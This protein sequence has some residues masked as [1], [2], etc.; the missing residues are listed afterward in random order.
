MFFL[1]LTVFVVIAIWYFFIKPLSYWKLR[2]VHHSKTPWYIFGDSWRTFQLLNGKSAYLGIYDFSVPTLCITDPEII[3]KI[4][5]KDFDSFVDHSI[6][7]IDPEI[8]P[9]WGSTL[10]TSTG[11]HWKTLRTVL[12]P[13]FTSSKLKEMFNLVLEQSQN[14]VKVISEREGE[15][16]IR[17]IISRFTNDVIASTAFGANVNSLKEPNNEFY[18]K[19]LHFTNFQTM[20]ILVRLLLLRFFPALSKKMGL[21]VIDNETS[22]FFDTVIKDTIKER[23]E[24][25]FKRLDMINTFLEVLQEQQNNPE[26]F[27]KP[28]TELDLL[29]NALIFYF[30]GFESVASTLS[31]GMYEL[32]LN[33]DIQE[34]LR[35]EIQEVTAKHST[36]TLDVVQSMTY[37]DMVV[38]EILRKWPPFLSTDR[39]LTKPYTLETND[40]SNPLIHL[41]YE[42]RIFVPIYGLHHDP[43]YFP[44]P[45][46]FDPERFSESNKASINAYTYM[47]FGIGPRS[48][49]GL[50]FALMEVKALLFNVLLNFEIE[51]APRTHVP[52]KIQTSLFQ[53][54]MEGGIWLKFNRL[55]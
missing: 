54:S 7:S 23:Q 4:M 25:G 32:A 34:N 21:S 40:K 44:N 13:F 52:A 8:D 20:S 15:M 5:V 1:L 2:H 22:V 41:G 31:F 37:M 30:G 47:P 48:C 42:N 38:S 16:D 50:R 18:K 19:G 29:A 6:A 45:E 27:L 11:K 10:L 17:E 14:F 55:K 12:S 39:R 24:R 9:V 46:K 3:K 35:R 49:I 28:V 43:D 36:I 53:Y 51:L 33:K 26:K